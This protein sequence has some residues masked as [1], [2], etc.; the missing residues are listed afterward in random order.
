[1]HLIEGFLPKPISPE[2]L[3]R[4]AQVWDNVVE[5]GLANVSDDD[6]RLYLLEL[7]REVTIR[8]VK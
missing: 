8:S 7:S 3:Q 6:Q 1:M 4:L 5:R 2:V